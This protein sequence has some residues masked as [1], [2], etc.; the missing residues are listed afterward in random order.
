M[1]LSLARSDDKLQ[2]EELRLGLPGGSRGELQGVV[3]GP[4]E[5]PAFDGS[6]SLRGTSLVRFAGWATA[7]AWSFDPRRRRQ[8]RR[9]HAVVAVAGPRRCA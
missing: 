8:F 7:G 4:P 9:A 2:I 6:I 3:S 5:A 1:R